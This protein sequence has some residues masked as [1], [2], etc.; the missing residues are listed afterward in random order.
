M[1]RQKECDF[2]DICCVGD[3]E[4]YVV[5]MKGVIFYHD[6]KR[7]HDLDSP[8]NQHLQSVAPSSEGGVYVAGKGGVLY[9]GNKD[10]WQFIGD[11]G[12]TSDFWSVREFNGNVY[13]SDATDA[14]LKHDGVDL[15]KV[16]MGIEYLVNTNKLDCKDGVLWSFG[17]DDLVKF[18]GARW[19]Y[20]TCPENE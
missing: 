10:G 8:T 2:L 9:K 3:D 15:S 5:G 7:W 1:E 19:Q 6:G 14:L 12:V 17:I 20:I 11:P 18:D 16:N 4:V 13:I